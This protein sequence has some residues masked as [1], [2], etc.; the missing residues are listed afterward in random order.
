LV[1]GY[2]LLVIGYW[3]LSPQSLVLTEKS[4]N[5]EKILLLMKFVLNRIQLMLLGFCLVIAGM[6]IQRL[7][8][9]SRGALAYGQV[10]KIHHWNERS[11]RRS[12]SSYSAAIIQF[13]AGSREIVFQAV[14]DMDVGTDAS[15]KILYNKET[16]TDAYVFSFVG[17]W[18][19]P[20]LYCAF[21][22]LIIA[23]L[24]LSLIEMSEK[25]EFNLCPL[26]I[27]RRNNKEEFPSDLP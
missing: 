11:Y 23:M 18:C 8:I 16:P 3:L 22:F 15:V 26:K 9:I 17:F 24:S 19:M 27:R 7:Y 4:F 14:T 20:L 6:L 12:T 5:I 13:T 10:I 21:I 25:I 1:I 2:W